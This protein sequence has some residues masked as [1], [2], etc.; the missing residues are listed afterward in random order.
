[1]YGTP[2]WALPTLSKIHWLQWWRPVPDDGELN[3]NSRMDDMIQAM[4]D[5]AVL[6]RF[7]FKILIS[8][9]AK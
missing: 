7:E 9:F 1:M 2:F 6:Y 3:S 8:A 5:G 4:V